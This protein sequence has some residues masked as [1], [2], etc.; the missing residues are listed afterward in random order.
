MYPWRPR[1]DVSSFQCFENRPCLCQISS[2]V[3]LG[4][5]S[6]DRRQ[7][8]PPLFPPPCSLISRDRLVAA[9]S[10]RDL[11][12]QPV[13]G[14]DSCDVDKRKS[15]FSRFRSGNVEF[16]TEHPGDMTL[17]CASRDHVPQ[18]KQR[19]KDDARSASAV[20]LRINMRQS[21]SAR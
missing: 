13:R 12:H 6:K 3:A 11:A 18:S 10:L 7:Q 2:V 20:L 15:R 21:V 17:R 5:P 9:P 14:K 4:K 8:F 19:A 16:G 1:P